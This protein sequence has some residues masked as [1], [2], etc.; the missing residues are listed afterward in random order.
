MKLNKY[1]NKCVK[2]LDYW[3]HEYEGNCSFNC[4]EYDEHEFGRDEE[5]LQILSYLFYKSNIKKITILENGFVD[6]YGL[7]E[8][9]IVNEGI[10]DIIDAIEYE[11]NEHICRIIRCIKDSNVYNKDEIISRM[12]GYLK[13]NKDLDVINELNKC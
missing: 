11:D 7:L 5:S 3:N 13:N 2:I 8:K 12:K 10:D 1:D 4:R 9:E 6:D